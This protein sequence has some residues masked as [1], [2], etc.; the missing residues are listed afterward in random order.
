MYEI[1]RIKLVPQLSG[2]NEYWLDIPNYK[3]YYQ[4]SNYGSVRSLDRIIKD[5]NGKTQAIKGKVLKLRINSGGYHCVGLSKNGNKATFSVHQLVAQTFIPNPDNKRTVNHINGIKTDNKISNLEW[6]TYSE[7]LFHAYDSGLRT[8]ISL[9][10]I[11]Q[12]NYKCKLKPE[13]VIE[14]KRLLTAGN[15]T[16]Q[17]IAN[18]FGVSISTVGSIKRNKS[19]S[20][21]V[22]T[23]EEKAKTITRNRGSKNNFS[24]LDENLVL[25]IKAAIN[26][27]VAVKSIASKY[28]VTP[29]TIYEIKRGATWQHVLA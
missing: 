1:S 20:Y 5:K 12:K 14:I 4:I 8:P 7:N 9:K 28:G 18:R 15:L 23:E 2:L 19:W 29:S 16:H 26:R 27:N 17:E 11:G 21:I 22:V 10:S 3:G 24:K 6:T 13:Q 25:K